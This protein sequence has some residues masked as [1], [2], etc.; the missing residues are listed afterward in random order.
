[1]SNNT[2][3]LNKLGFKVSLTL[4][5]LMTYYKNNSKKKLTYC[6][7][8]RTMRGN[9]LTCD[10]CPW[11]Q[12]TYETCDEFWERC[13]GVFQNIGYLRK[14]KIHFWTEIRIPQIKDWLEKIHNRE[15]CPDLY[16]K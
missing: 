12:L 7:L 6:P 1:M 3:H 11:L 5:N 15:T 4:L 2:K 13:L 14:H 8:C 10:D 16:K 9:K